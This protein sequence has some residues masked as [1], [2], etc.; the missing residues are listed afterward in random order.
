MS[1]QNLK[2]SKSKIL[3]KIMRMICFSSKILKKS[4]SWGFMSFF[5]TAQI[6]WDIYVPIGLNGDN[7]F[8][9]VGT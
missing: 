8:R 1:H 3:M 7:N 5:S 6:C 2:L 4:F 9:V